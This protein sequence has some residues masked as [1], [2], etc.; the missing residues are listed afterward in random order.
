MIVKS[1]LYCKSDNHGNDL[2]MRIFTDE[3]N[4]DVGATIFLKLKSESKIRNIGQV[5]FNDHSFH[6][7][8]DSS[9]H[10]HYVSKSYG[11]NWTIINDADL[12]IKSVHLIVDRSEKYVI[13]KSIIDK[14]G[15]FLNFKQQGFELQKFVPMD[16]IRTFRDEG[17]DSIAE[18]IIL[19]DPNHHGEEQH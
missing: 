1:R 14:F 7:L 3:N 12:N 19:K 10:F 13:P 4:V 2:Y 18:P 6:V 17:Y 9:K 16:M 15:K 8:R 11:F 5:F